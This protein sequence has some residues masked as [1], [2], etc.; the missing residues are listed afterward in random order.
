[1]LNLRLISIVAVI[2]LA[3]SCKQKVKNEE[4]DIYKGEI[5]F[6]DTIRQLGQFSVT[7]PIQTSEFTFKNTGSVPVVVLSVEPSCRC[8]SAKYT[9]EA[10]RP[11]ENGKITVIFDGN[12]SAPGYFDKSVRIR[13]NS[14]RIYTLRINGIMK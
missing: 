1:M 12:E 6:V 13:I 14:Q 11:G 10:I 9:Q 2:V 8:I 3:T 7:V 4:K 5:V